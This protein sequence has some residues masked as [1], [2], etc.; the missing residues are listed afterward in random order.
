MQVE[1][2][3]KRNE[4]RANFLA[5]NELACQAQHDDRA[6]I[7]PSLKLADMTEHHSN[8]GAELRPRPAHVPERLEYSTVAMVT[9]SWSR[10]PQALGSAG[11]RSRIP[12]KIG[13]L[14]GLP[15]SGRL[16]AYLCIGWPKKASRSRTRASRLARTHE[17]RYI[18]L[19]RNS[20]KRKSSALDHVPRWKPPPDRPRSSG[21]FLPA[22]SEDS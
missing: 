20:C 2:P 18:W 3:E 12:E 4:V 21:R 9:T 8:Y 13:D 5:V 11:C 22:F 19:R 1:R 16:V 14:L 17:Y 7:C 10:A 6:R 15:S